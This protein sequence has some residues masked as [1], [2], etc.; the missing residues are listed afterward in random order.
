[1]VP[2]PWLIAVFAAFLLGSASFAAGLLLGARALWRM[3]G[4]EGSFWKEPDAAI[5]DQ[6]EMD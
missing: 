1:M 3:G 2:W 6:G 4:K 5:I